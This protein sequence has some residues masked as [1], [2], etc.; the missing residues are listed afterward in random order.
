MLAV[1]LMV[2]GFLV[3]A[4]VVTVVEDMA[5]R[6]A[7]K[8]MDQRCTHHNNRHALVVIF[9]R[10][11]GS[12]LFSALQN[13]GCPRRLRIVL[14]E[15]VDEFTESSATVMQYATMMK[16]RGRYSI[17]FTDQVIV[18]QIVGP[19]S[20]VSDAL[21]FARSDFNGE[22]FIFI[23][24]STTEFLPDWDLSSVQQWTTLHQPDALMNLGSTDPAFPGFTKACTFTGA[25]PRV[26]TVPLSRSG[27]SV[28]CVL[29]ALPFMAHSRLL[30]TIVD[31]G[32]V[33]Q[34]MNDLQLRLSVQVP[35]V[36]SSAT[37][38]AI[39]PVEPLPAQSIDHAGAF[40]SKGASA[41]DLIMGL[42]PGATIL[43]KVAKYGSLSSVQW[44]LRSVVTS[45]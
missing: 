37:A 16:A 33:A 35:L 19:K 40:V 31:A 24:H 12:T 5:R 8:N 32:L 43:E 39:I 4:R 34:G 26:C 14:V 27:H 22:D 38:Q 3:L 30:N 44:A 41:V 18:H 17:D 11:V 23:A 20:L 21:S 28:P 15:E 29:A 10:N 25:V 6:K 36:M 9:G 7:M 13:A 45:G 2:L 1:I 42:Q